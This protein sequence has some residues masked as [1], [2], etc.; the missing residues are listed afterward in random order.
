MIRT[1]VRCR[2]CGSHLGHLFPDGPAPTGDRYCMN[3][4]A[5]DLVPRTKEAEQTQRMPRCDRG[6]NDRTTAPARRVG[7]PRNPLPS[8]PTHGF[9]IAAQLK[10]SGDLGRVWS[11]SRALTYRSLEQLA[12][13]GLHPRSRRGA[14]D[15]R[16]QSHDPCRDAVG[17]GAASQVAQHARRTPAR[18][19]QR[20]APQADHRRPMRHRDRRHAGSATRAHR[21]DG[22]CHRKSGRQ[23]APDRCRRPLAQRVVAGRA[24]FPRPTETRDLN[25][26]SESGKANPVVVR[27]EIAAPT[28][29]TS[30]HDGGNGVRSGHVGGSGDHGARCCAERLAA[31]R[32]HPADHVDAGTKV[33]GCGELPV[34]DADHDGDRD[35]PRQH[36]DRTSAASTDA[37]TAR[38]ATTI[39]RDGDGAG[40]EDSGPVA[41]GRV[42]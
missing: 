34:G 19:A 41:V 17:P 2:R 33:V 3:S 13:R 14:G 23:R 36:C 6:E 7:M 25:A 31:P 9:A 11:L 42:G 20:A 37:F 29:D 21:G 24:A 5:L 39:T 10:P 35:R 38:N 26:P 22:S 32:R 15:R 16:W 4:L 28:A 30:H 27:N 12:N 18:S 40:R 1:E 8:A